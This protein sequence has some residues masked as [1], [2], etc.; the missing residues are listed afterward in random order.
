MTNLAKTPCIYK[1]SAKHFEFSFS[2]ADTF[3]NENRNGVD[4]KMWIGFSKFLTCLDS[5]LD[6]FESN[7]EIFSE[8]IVN[9]YRSV[10]LKNGSIMRATSSF[11]NK[12]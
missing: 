5:Y 3:F 10:T 11:H 6:L 1:F 7:I 12:P 2:K 8:T 4:H 9:I